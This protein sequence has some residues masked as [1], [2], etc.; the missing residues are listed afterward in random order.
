MSEWWASLHFLR[1]QWLWLLLTVPTI[2]LSFRIRD[3]VR[4]RWKRYI[5]PAL[6]DHLIVARRRRWRFRPIHM[7]SFLIFLGVIAVAGPTWRREQPPFTEDKALLVIALDLSDTMNAIDLDPT[8][9]ERVKLKLRDLLKVRNGGRTA[10]FVYA[11]TTHL[12]L[13]FTTDTSLLNL[14]LDSLT[15]SIMPVNGKDTARALQTIQDFLRDE[16]VP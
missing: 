3:D 6:L 5:D 13:P 8:R 9:L 11:G 12:V 14:Y 16:T 7:I 10:L 4:S 15:T 1:P 2:Y